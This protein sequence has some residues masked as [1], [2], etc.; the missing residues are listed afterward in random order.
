MEK[1]E[2]ILRVWQNQT[3]RMTDTAFV[4][5]VEESAGI[6]CERIWFEDADGVRMLERI[7]DVMEK[8]FNFK[9]KLGN[10]GY[11]AL[12][13]DLELYVISLKN[14]TETSEIRVKTWTRIESIFARLSHM[15]KNLEIMIDIT[16]DE[17]LK[18]GSKS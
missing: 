13:G 6:M 10:R 5:Y 17:N 11:E 14:D 9:V 12:E 4:K 18:K 15:A 1:I 7:L 3:R 2:G 8:W 16:E